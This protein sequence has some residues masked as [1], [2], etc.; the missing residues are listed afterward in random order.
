MIPEYSS[1]K[2]EIKNLKFITDEGQKYSKTA[3]L[4]FLVPKQ[5]HPVVELLGHI[6]QHD[7]FSML[8]NKQ[9]INLDQCY[10]NK[11]SLKEYRQ[12]RNMDPKDHIEIPG[13]SAKN[14]FFDSP[15]QFD[16]SYAKITENEFTLESSYIA[17]GQMNFKNSIF[18]CKQVNLSNVFFREGNFDFSNVHNDNADINF[19]NAIFGPGKKD[20]QYTNFGNGD[21]FFTNTEFGD[22]EVSFINT[23]F[24][25]GDLSFKVARFGTGMISFHYAKFGVGDKT[26]ERSEFGNGMVDFR[27]VE[28]GKGKINFNRASFG[29]GD[30]SFEG[31]ELLEG[32][33]SMKRAQF[34]RG[35]FSFELGEYSDI[36]LDLERTEFGEGVISF[37][38]SK[39]K[40]LSLNSCHLDHYT[41]LRVAKCSYID[42]SNTIVR[43]IIDLKPYEFKEEIYTL[44]F[45]GMRLIGRIYIDWKAN[46]V[47]QLVKR[48]QD[49]SHRLKS[50]QY[51][52]LKENFSL[53][54]QY[55]DEDSSYVEFKRHE[56]IADL[57]ES[58]KS[59]PISAIWNYP[60]YWFKLLLFDKAGL[61]ATNPA[62]VIFTMLV[63]YVFFSFLY[64]VLMTY[65]SADIIS[66]VNNP[67][68]LTDVGTAFYHSAITFFTIGYGDH[69]PVGFIRVLSGIEGFTGVFLMSYFTVAFVRKILR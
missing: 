46:N 58:V 5:T 57:Q 53:T 26:F 32:R 38:N 34:G 25:D 19:K 61:Y 51:R 14:S 4:T 7:I 45:V 36:D 22:G 15:F 63:S 69:F 39:L 8:D 13:F 10:I 37:Y 31:S 43:D 24:N 18:H 60:L 50:E 17:N 11:F 54:G 28:F 9:P 35:K 40:S 52:I 33:L 3:I 55:N 1:F 66:S 59:R 2:V 21:K 62:R 16:F 30:V 23:H 6:D 44:N 29:I 48:Q 27:T 67:D 41:D 68:K 49:I 47:N 65:T 42:L 20:F 12:I 56:A 64:Y